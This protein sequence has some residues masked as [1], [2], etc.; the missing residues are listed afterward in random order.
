M[1]TENT[2]DWP[3]D[4][5]GRVVTVGTAYWFKGETIL[6]ASSQFLYPQDKIPAGRVALGDL[7]GCYRVSTKVVIFA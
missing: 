1:G 5:P 4:R 2:V 3:P 6:W 7:L